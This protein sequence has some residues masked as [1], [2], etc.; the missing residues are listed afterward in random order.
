MLAE[1]REVADT[2]VI[3]PIHSAYFTFKRDDGKSVSELNAR[4]ENLAERLGARG[5][6]HHYADETL[7]AKYGS[8]KG[9]RLV[10]GKCS[11]SHRR[12]ARHEGT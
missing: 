11:Y 10:I 6:G 5:V 1:S 9:R 2:V 12:R 3:H 7:L 4:F 8:V